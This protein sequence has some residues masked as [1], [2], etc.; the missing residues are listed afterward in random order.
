[1]SPNPSS[2]EMIMQLCRDIICKM[3]GYPILHEMK[4]H[5]FT[6][7]WHE[8]KKSRR[9]GG[10]NNICYQ[11]SWKNVTI[12]G[13][14]CVSLMKEMCWQYRSICGNVMCRA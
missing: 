7:L 3:R 8:T 12:S 10:I 2:W 9:T 5:V 6:S 4:C 14:E 11:H 1:M 13:S